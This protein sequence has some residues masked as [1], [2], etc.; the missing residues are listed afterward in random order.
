[1]S[2]RDASA[3]HRRSQVYPNPTSVAADTL[4]CAHAPLGAPLTYLPPFHQAHEEAR[5]VEQERLNKAAQLD[6]VAALD[7][8]LQHADLSKNGTRFTTVATLQL[9]YGWPVVWVS[10]FEPVKSCAV[11]T[12]TEMRMP[13]AAVQALV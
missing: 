7:A 12:H 8:L 1:L 6:R 5:R 3:V 4:G 9:A 2:G 11:M 13:S 10:G